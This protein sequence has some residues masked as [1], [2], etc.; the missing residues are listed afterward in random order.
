[1]C[2][3]SAGAFR[4]HGLVLIVS[5]WRRIQDVGFIFIYIRKTLI[6]CGLRDE[7][8]EKVNRYLP[9]DGVRQERTAI[10]ELDCVGGMRAALIGKTYFAILIDL[11]KP[12]WNFG[13]EEGVWL[14]RGGWW[15]ASECN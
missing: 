3:K 7:G 9:S 12:V 1:M 10:E 6:V 4:S 8:E 2:N 5:P 14:E 11:A 13:I 15:G